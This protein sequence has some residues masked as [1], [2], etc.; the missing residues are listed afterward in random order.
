MIWVKNDGT[1]PCVGCSVFSTEL[2]KMIVDS[3]AAEMIAIVIVGLLWAWVVTDG[4]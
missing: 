2:A 4:H 1:R 3:I